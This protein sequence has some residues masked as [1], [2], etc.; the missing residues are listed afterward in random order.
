MSSRFLRPA[1]QALLLF[2]MTFAVANAQQVSTQDDPVSLVVN[3][4]TDLF[5]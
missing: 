1:V 2:C 5:K 3:G 4:M